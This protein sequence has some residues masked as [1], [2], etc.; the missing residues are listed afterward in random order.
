MS[1][2]LLT[3]RHSQGWGWG[4]PWQNVSPLPTKC[5]VQKR[6]SLI[7]QLHAVNNANVICRAQLETHTFSNP[8][9]FNMYLMMARRS[10]RWSGRIFLWK[11]SNFRYHHIIHRWSLLFHFPA[12]VFYLSEENRKILKSISLFEV[13]VLS[14]HHSNE[15]LLKKPCHW[16]N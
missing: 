8:N 5:V 2:V 6:E 1:T 7:I 10:L 11:K 4:P 15:I 13:L 3:Q 9:Y 16:F 14:N 12:L